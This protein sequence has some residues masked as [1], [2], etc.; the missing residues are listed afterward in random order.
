MMAARRDLALLR[1]WGKLVKMDPNRLCSKIYRSR[2]AHTRPG[3]WCARVR[4]ILIELGLG[5]IWETQEIGD[6]KTW[7][8]KVKSEMA[9]RERRNWLQRVMVKDKLRTYRT[10]RTDLRFEEYLTLVPSFPQRREISKL[11][12]GT[13][14]LQMEQGRWMKQPETERSCVLCFGAGVEDEIHL[15]LDCAAF[16]D[17]RSLMFKSIQRL[18]GNYYDLSQMREDRWW[19]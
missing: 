12:C 4:D 13:N 8:W 19:M 6:L 9:L 5:E 18:T 10:I 15:L 7:N 11:R 14:E 2:R 17:L 16:N 3:S 1:W